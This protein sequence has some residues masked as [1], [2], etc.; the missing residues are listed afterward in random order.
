M[1]LFYDFYENPP[2][3]NSKPRLHA[4]IISAGTVD[5]DVLAKEIHEKSTLTTGD[6]KATLAMLQI[7]MANLLK[8]GYRV[9]LDGIG[10]F[11]LT[12]SCPPVYTTKDVRAESIHPKSVSFR[13]EKSFLQEFKALRPVRSKEKRHSFKHS[14]IE[15][16][17]LLA[18]FFQNNDHITSRMFQQLCGFTRTTAHRRLKQLVAAGKLQSIG[19]HRSPLYIPL[20]SQVRCDLL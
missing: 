7:E 6:V 18:N 19:H 8:S 1:E 11:E 3:G 12:L 13:P 5:S 2:K 4:R 14:E 16:D 17:R 10:Y 20:K 15:L 9:H